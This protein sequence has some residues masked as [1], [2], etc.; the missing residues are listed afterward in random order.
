MRASVLSHLRLCLPL[1]LLALSLI[2][3]S[4]AAL[5]LPGLGGSGASASKP[6]DSAQLNQLK[7]LRDA[8]KPGAESVPSMW[9]VRAYD[10]LLYAAMDAAQRGEIAPLGM[11]SMVQK[12]FL[13]GAVDTRA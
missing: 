13:D 7:Q 10:S 2:H 11:A 9:L 3:P 12:L 4:A 5:S 1:I 8:T 6:V